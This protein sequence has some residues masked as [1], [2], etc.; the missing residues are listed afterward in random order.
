[1][2]AFN[3]TEET[4][5]SPTA[6]PIQPFLAIYDGPLPIKGDMEKYRAEEMAS[7]MKFVAF[8]LDVYGTGVRATDDTQAE[9][10][11]DALLEDPAEL[12]KRIEGGWDQLKRFSAEDSISVNTSAL[13][14][15]GYC[16][17]RKRGG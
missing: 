5:P 7:K 13:T 10:L 8:A 2:K 4:V 14:A 15:N 1:M 17:V 6:I 16:F 11:M 3:K 9:A 12:R